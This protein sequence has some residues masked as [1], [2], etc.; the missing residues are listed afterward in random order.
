MNFLS[1][2]K[3]WYLRV[4]LP[5]ENPSHELHFDHAEQLKREEEMDEL[6]DSLVNSEAAWQMR[7]TTS[8]DDH[9]TTHYIK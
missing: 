4:F 2:L 6:W 7:Y 9:Q 5:Y 3:Q 1:K 8:E